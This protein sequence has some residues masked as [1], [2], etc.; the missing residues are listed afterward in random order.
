M[1]MS[2]YVLLLRD[3]SC[4]HHQLKVKVLQACLEADVAVPEEVDKYFDGTD[5]PDYG[6]IIPFEAREY[7]G[8]HETG[9]EIDISELPEG[10]KTIRFLN[11]Y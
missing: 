3:G 5:D 11:S 1:G 8:E 4:P 7:N 10:V 6:L 2:T 9:V